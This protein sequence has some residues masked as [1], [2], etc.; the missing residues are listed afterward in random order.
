MLFFNFS[1]DN[2]VA[3]GNRNKMDDAGG[4]VGNVMKTEA[5]LASR[6]EAALIF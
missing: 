5:S 3:L 6:L 2:D 4:K 1:Y